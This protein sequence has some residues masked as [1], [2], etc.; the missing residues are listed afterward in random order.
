MSQNELVRSSHEL[1]TP[2]ERVARLNETAEEFLGQYLAKSTRKAYRDDVRMW[3]RY[4]SDIGIPADKMTVGTLVGFVR[5]MDMWHYASKTMH[6]RVTGLRSVSKAAGRP[7]PGDVS[8][9]AGQ[10]LSIVD[11]KIAKSGEPRGRGKAPAI[12]IAQLRDI[13]HACPDTLA[14]ARD[15][16]LLLLGFGIA[17]RSAE[18]ASLH[19][20]DIIETPEGLIVTIR[21]GKTGGREVAV[22]YGTYLPTCPVRNWVIWKDVAQLTSGP[23]LRHIDRHEYI[24]G[25]LTAQGIGAVVSRAAQRAGLEGRT[26]HGLRSGLATEARRAGRDAVVIAAQ[27]GWSPNSRELFG[28]MQIVDRWSDNAVAGIGL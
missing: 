17:G 19:V 23:A 11:E 15:R 14:G 5:W 16:A 7:I 3:H 6:R 21:Y 18:V 22:P 26:S 27:G 13:S 4:C 8:E 9:A 10:A 20:G 12:T 2:E 1:M 25:G 28:Y 24:R